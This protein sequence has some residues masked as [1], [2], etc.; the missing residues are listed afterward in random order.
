MKKK[1]TKRKTDYICPSHHGW[2]ENEIVAV[3][4]LSH[5]EGVAKVFSGTMHVPFLL[6][7]K[8][9]RDV[10]WHLQLDVALEIDGTTCASSG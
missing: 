8:A 9:T 10:G 6:N 2:F 3:A 1:K 5:K 4:T 7:P